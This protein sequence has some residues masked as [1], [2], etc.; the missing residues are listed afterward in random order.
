MERKIILASKSPRRKQILADMGYRFEIIPSEYEEVLPD[1][2][3]EPVMIQELA[4]NKANDVAKKLGGE[5]III[6]ADTMV[7]HNKSVLGKPSSKEDAFRMLTNLSNDKHYVVTGIAVIDN[8]TATIQKDF[9]ITYVTFNELT[10]KMI[11]DYIENYNPL[12]KA[13]AYGI[14]ELP[15]GFV[16]SVE[17]EF[18][19]VV[20]LPSKALNSMLQKILV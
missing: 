2:E 3:F 4:F 14:Q 5:F 1:K 9:V 13:G 6:G 11:N 18:D 10:D 8:K 7:I 15:A 19:N 20:G 16:K 12:D 17:G